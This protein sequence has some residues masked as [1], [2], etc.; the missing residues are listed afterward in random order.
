MQTEVAKAPSDI[1]VGGS[2]LPGELLARQGGELVRQGG[3][4]GK[5]GPALVHGGVVGGERGGGCLF[6]HDVDGCYSHDWRLL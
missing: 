3:L 6:R 4:V 1:W 5:R 2:G